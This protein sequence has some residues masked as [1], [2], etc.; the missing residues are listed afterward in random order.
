MKK[1]N[2]DQNNTSGQSAGTTDKKET[3]AGS[4]AFNQGSKQDPAY[5]DGTP[6]SD[7]EKETGHTPMPGKEKIQRKNKSVG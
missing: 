5:K 3:N 1:K 2:T 7:E 6:V 4:G